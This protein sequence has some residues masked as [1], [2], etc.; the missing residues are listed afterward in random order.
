M[1]AVSLHFVCLFVY[2]T[3]A[4]FQ[5][6]SKVFIQVENNKYHI[7]ETEDCSLPVYEPVPDCNLRFLRETLTALLAHDH[8]P[9][10]SLSGA[11]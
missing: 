7:Q 9:Q 4:N 8:L 6:L 2:F 10:I 11:A 3:R 1:L 5:N